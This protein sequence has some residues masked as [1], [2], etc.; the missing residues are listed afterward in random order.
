MEKN[1]KKWAATARPASHHERDHRDP[2]NAAR[3]DARLQLGA[4]R[5]GEHLAVGQPRRTGFAQDDGGGHNRPGEGATSG[6][7]HASDQWAGA[8]SA[9]RR[10]R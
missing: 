4:G 7:V 10:S 3:A 6:L 2:E 5:G 9:L 8:N 1:F